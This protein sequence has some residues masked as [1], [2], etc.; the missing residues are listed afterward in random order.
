MA[1]VVTPPPAL[2]DQWPPSFWLPSQVTK[3]THYQSS[4]VLPRETV[5][6]VVIGSGFSGASFVYHYTNGENSS[7]VV[8]LEARA[9]CSGATARNG[10]HMAPNLLPINGSAAALKRARFERRN[11]DAVKA[12]INDNGIETA[13][14]NQS[15]EGSGWLLYRSAKEFENAKRRL[16]HAVGADR[17]GLKIYNSTEALHRTGLPAPLS[18]A[19]A[20]P[21]FPI[22]TYELSAW[23]LT[24]ALAKG[25]LL[26]SDTP[27]TEVT[28]TDEGMYNVITPK[29]VV[30]TAKVVF[31]TNAYTNYF[32][33]DNNNSENTLSG[34]RTQVYP[35]RGQVSAHELISTD[36]EDNSPISGTN[37]NWEDEYCVQLEQDDETTAS[38]KRYL[39]YGGCRRYG[40]EQQVGPNFEDDNGIDSDVSSTLGDF[41]KSRVLPNGR[42]APSTKKVKEWTGIMGFT[43]DGN[44]LVGQ[45]KPNG[46]ATNNGLYVLAGFGGHGVPR[47]FLSAQ[48]LVERYFSD[49]EQGWPEWFPDEYIN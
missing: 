15:T 20:H 31:A 18:G 40:P 28:K 6:V 29:G 21:S 24:Q 4:S 47:I 10:G 17:E 38:K 11:L 37:L 48:A 41:F 22:N 46:N 5:D 2:N 45:L 3:L 26:Y 1:T 42:A 23:L 25:L 30:R 33:E 27:V 35:V 14:P 16:G 32:V 8:M 44:P 36:R 43:K 49:N 9:V 39:V 34:M 19:I 13:L 12:L 7:K